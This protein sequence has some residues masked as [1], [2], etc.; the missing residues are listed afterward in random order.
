MTQG[1]AK[2]ASDK[3][4]MAAAKRLVVKI[5]SALLVD[6]KG[7]VTEMGGGVSLQ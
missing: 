2:T 3:T 4:G 7:N 5:G 1:R 6:E